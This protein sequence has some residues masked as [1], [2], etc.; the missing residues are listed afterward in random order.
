[1]EPS[2]T[3]LAS[4]R[5]RNV[6]LGALSA[7]D[8]VSVV[9]RLLAV[10]AQEHAFSRWSVGQRVKRP[11]EAAVLA[12][13]ARNDIVRTHILRP[14]W[15]Y[16]RG[17]DLRWL[18][19]L[20]G[21]R[22]RSLNAGWYRNHG[23]DDDFFLATRTVVEAELTGGRCRTRDELKLALT[24]AG[25][26]VTGQRITV[27]LFDLELHTVICSGPVRGRHHTYGLVDE[28]LPPSPTLATDGATARLVQRYLTGHG[29]A[30]LKDL[31]WWST[32]TLKQLQGAVED[33]GDAVQS[34]RVGGEE[35]LWL[36][37]EEPTTV[38]SGASDSTHQQFRLL[39]V[40]DELFVGYSESRGLVDPDGEFGSV[41]PMGFT[42]MMHVVLEGDRLAGRW[43]TDKRRMEPSGAQGLE[44]TLEMNRPMSAGDVRGIELAVEAYGAFVGVEARAVVLDPS[45]R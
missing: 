13:I 40:F 11:D 27:A 43:R 28:L 3:D 33:L 19:G 14:T 31:R 8:P 39:Q 4:A 6:L 22:V 21:H 9:D 15:H 45:T 26:D 5:V 32:L 23:V 10:Q 20:T 18:Q 2:S 34:A 30:L 42:K 17:E 1:M 41:L 12:A 25:I 16:V 35:Y 24:E 29:P 36:A 37:D 7:T 44:V 38:A